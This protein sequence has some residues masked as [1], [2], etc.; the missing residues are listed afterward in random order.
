MKINAKI[1][2]V[3]P[4][5]TGTG[6]NGDWTKLSFI[7][8]TDFSGR[9]VDVYIISWGDRINQNHLIVGNIVEIGIEIKSRE[10][11]GRWYTDIIGQELSVI[12]LAENEDVSR[13][14]PLEENR[15]E[16]DDNDSEVPF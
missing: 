16:K 8:S 13:S 3:L 5:Q 1:S 2:Q 12:R 11:N 9:T 10:Y 14:I 15:N 7:V 6:T 4:A